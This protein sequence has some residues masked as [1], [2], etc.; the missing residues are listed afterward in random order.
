MG[1]AAAQLAGSGIGVGL[2]AKGIALIHR[3]NLPRAELAAV[4]RRLEAAD[5][6]LCAA[7]LRDAAA[8][9]ERRGLLAPG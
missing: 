2:Q 9:Y 5:S 7:L 4:V 6:P 3:R 8:V 1:L